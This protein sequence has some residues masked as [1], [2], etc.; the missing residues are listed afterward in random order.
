MKL[1]N[2]IKP[3]ILRNELF[4]KLILKTEN[5]T[6]SAGRNYLT[7]FKKFNEE[8]NLRLSSLNPDIVS[9]A[10]IPPPPPLKSTIPP[11]PP[12]LL[13]VPPPPPPGLLGVP[14]P[15][16]PGLILGIGSVAGGML[17]PPPGLM[18]ALTGVGRI[19][20]FA[21]KDPRPAAGVKLRSVFVNTLE[22]N[23]LAET[24]WVKEE[25]MLSKEDELITLPWKQLED[26]FK[27]KVTAKAKDP[28]AEENQKEKLASTKEGILDDRKVNQFEIILSRFPLTREKTK[29]ALMTLKITCDQATKILELLP[30]DKVNI[31]KQGMSTNQRMDW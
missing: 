28:I 25:K 4:R 7:L 2:F 17:A 24:F 9:K 10:T 27:L 20:A 16:P 14:P 22:Q 18:A 31:T 6:R 26:D 5:D 13:G 3:R 11:P 23:K 21:S 12:G 30:E 8:K 19:A 1:L 29:E 15:P